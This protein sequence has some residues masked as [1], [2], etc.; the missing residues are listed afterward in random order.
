MATLSVI[1]HTRN[2]DKTLRR[3]LESVQSLADE[4]LVFD[5]ESTD[6][7]V[8]I[9]KKF[10][11]KVIPVK[12]QL[13][14]G[15]ARNYALK[16]ASKEWTLVL[17]AD[18]ALSPDLLQFINKIKS[19]TVHPELFKDYYWLP[20]QNMIWDAWVKTAGWWPDYQL[21]L[22]KTGAVSWPKVGVHDVPTPMG[23]GVYLPAE[24]N[25]AIIHLNYQDV[26]AFDERFHRYTTIESGT[27]GKQKISSAELLSSLLSEWSRRF[28]GQDGWQGGNRG[29]A[30]SLFQ[31]FYD[32][33]IRMK[34]HQAAGFPV[35][36]ST[37]KQNILALQSANTNL[38]FW[39]A[40]TQQHHAPMFLKPYW[41]I[42]KKLKV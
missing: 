41:W 39:L 38:N 13:H 32:A 24:Q 17:D 18:E 14:A 40:H 28:F 8:R 35:G 11:A 9:A 21:R 25:Y 5:M 36:K 1:I 26:S 27:R 20:R 3:T 30:L 15:P 34:Q 23:A 2:A 33:V 31:G 10:G 37:P 6:Q 4:I 42:R 7:T 12:H 22:F 19:E 29:M 16:Q